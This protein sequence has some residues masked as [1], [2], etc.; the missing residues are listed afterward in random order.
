MIFLIILVALFAEASWEAKYGDNHGFI[1]NLTL[2]ATMLSVQ[3]IGLILG[4]KYAMFDYII[5]RFT[6]FDYMFSFFRY[7]HIWYIGTTSLHDKILNGVNKYL[8]FA[9]RIIIILGLIIY[10][11]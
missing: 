3:I 10:L 8:L 11:S 9:I 6:L 2:A 7:G 5:L 4:Y 1:S